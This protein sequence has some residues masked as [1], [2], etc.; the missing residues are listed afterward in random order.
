MDANHPI[1]PNPIPIVKKGWIG[2]LHEQSWKLSF[3]QQDK[4]YSLQSVCFLRHMVGW[5]FIPNHNF[6]NCNLLSWN[7]IQ[8][9]SRIQSKESYK[10]TGDLSDW[11]CG[12]EWKC[13]CVGIHSH[14][15]TAAITFTWPPSYSSANLHPNF[16]LWKV[17]QSTIQGCYQCFMMV[18]QLGSYCW[19]GIYS[20]INSKYYHKMM[21]KCTIRSLCKCYPDA[22][23]VHMK[24]LKEAAALS[25]VLES[26]CYVDCTLWGSL[27]ALHKKLDCQSRLSQMRIQGPSVLWQILPPQV[28]F[29]LPLYI[30]MLWFPGA[31][32]RE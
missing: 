27:L 15:G 17:R 29:A 25:W 31:Q 28:G 8:R 9:I 4:G 12:F 13:K 26:Q 24:R 21:G 6:N 1:L 19:S 2:Y 23:D 22:E 18:M 16:G 11:F 14:L 7:N 32:H 30:D 20:H 3:Y 5:V 10:D